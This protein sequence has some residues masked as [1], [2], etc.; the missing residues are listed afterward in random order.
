MGCSELR[1]IFPEWDTFISLAH[2]CFPKL[3]FVL[4]E[5]LDEG[6]SDSNTDQDAGSSEEE[7]EEEEEDG[8]EDEEGTSVAADKIAQYTPRIISCNPLNS[9]S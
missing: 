2:S 8:E 6:D 7:E 3:N 9:D 5:I 4:L 1:I